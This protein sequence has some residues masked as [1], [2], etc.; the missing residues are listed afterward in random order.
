MLGGVRQEEM[1]ALDEVLTEYVARFPALPQNGH[2]W[3]N[4]RTTAMYRQPQSYQLGTELPGVQDGVSMGGSVSKS[5]ALLLFSDAFCIAP[6]SILPK[7]TKH[8]L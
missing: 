6:C 4:I 7:A 8:I 2:L 3:N 1:Q 5:A